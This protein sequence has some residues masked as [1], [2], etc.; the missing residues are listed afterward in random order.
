MQFVFE[1]LLFN[2]K[3]AVEIFRTNITY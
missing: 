2:V 1:R 3:S